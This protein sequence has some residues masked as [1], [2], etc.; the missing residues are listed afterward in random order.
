MENIT[1]TGSIRD[2][3]LRVIEDRHE[4]VF[5]RAQHFFPVADALASEHIARIFSEITMQ[6]IFS[7]E[8]L[9]AKLLEMFDF[10]AFLNYAEKIYKVKIS[11][12]IITASEHY[13]ETGREYEERKRYL[14]QLK[15]LFVVCE[16]TLISFVVKYHDRPEEGEKMDS[17]FYKVFTGILRYMHAFLKVMIYVHNSR[18]AN[19]GHIK[20]FFDRMNAKPH[21]AIVDDIFDRYVI[22]TPEDLFEV[23]LTDDD[24]A[25]V[26]QALIEDFRSGISGNKK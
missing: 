9:A 13:F 16:K 7:K 22:V 3:I 18:D 1:E 21:E 14:T 25:E 26:I 6:D 17:L 5:E 11:E 10:I 24:I 23:K 20:Y 12:V 15:E 19:P 4:K 8:S 2:N